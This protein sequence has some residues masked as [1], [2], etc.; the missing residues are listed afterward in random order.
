M[1]SIIMTEKYAINIFMKQDY[2]QRARTA[3]L[4]RGKFACAEAIRDQH[5]KGGGS[6][7]M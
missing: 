1:T 3:H 4:W 2:Q 5:P 6:E 7:R